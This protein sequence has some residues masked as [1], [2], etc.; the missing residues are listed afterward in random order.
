M[1][2]FKGPGFYTYVD[3]N[4]QNLTDFTGLQAQKPDNLPL[5]TPQK[6]WNPFADGFGEA[7]NRLNSPTK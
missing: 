6:F 3:N 7:L 2:F 4:P 1:R 5:G